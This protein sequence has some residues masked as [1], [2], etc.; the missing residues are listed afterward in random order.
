MNIAKG[1]MYWLTVDKELRAHFF[2]SPQRR[3]RLYTL[4]WLVLVEIPTIPVHLSTGRLR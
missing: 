3:L 1:S 2:P 4:T